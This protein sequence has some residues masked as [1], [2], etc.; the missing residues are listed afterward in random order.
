MLNKVNPGSNMYQGWITHTWNTVKGACPHDCSYCYMMRFKNQKPVR[1]DEKELKTNL[2][3]GNFI[4]VGSSCDLFAQAIPEAW[5]DQTLEKCRQNDNVYL[6]QTK[7]PANLRWYDGA[8]PERVRICTTIE[9]NRLYSV[10]MGIAPH[11]VNRAEAMSLLTEFPRYVTIEPI[12]D[13]DLTPM[14]ELIKKCDPLQVNIGADSGGNHLPEPS[15]DKVLALIYELQK[16]TTIARKS[17]LGRI[18][19]E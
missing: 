10:T 3:Q 14:V 4:F 8:M 16:F 7:N 17:N 19:K 11:P 9:T 15:A 12:L 13:F 1:F 5:I 2:G 18:L 6:F